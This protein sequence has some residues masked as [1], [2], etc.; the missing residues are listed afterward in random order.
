MPP[1]HAKRMIIKDVE[2]VQ[3]TD[4]WGNLTLW[5]CAISKSPKK[6]VSR[7]PTPS[8]QPSP[9]R[10]RVSFS[11]QDA[12]PPLD[13][14]FSLDP[15]SQTKSSQRKPKVVSSAAFLFPFANNDDFTDRK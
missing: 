6:V 7:P 11:T 12:R 3:T 15:S 2:S 4:R 5:T 14:G 13:Q 9:K 10:P 1:K 8:S